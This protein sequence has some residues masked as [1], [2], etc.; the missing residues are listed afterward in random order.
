MVVAAGEVTPSKGLRESRSRFSSDVKNQ[1]WDRARLFP[2]REGRDP[3]RW[4]LDAA[5]N[6]VCRALRGC[7]GPLCMEFD[8]I[9]PKSR[10]GSGS[11]ENCQVLQSRLN[12]RKA[13]EFPPPE[14]KTLRVWS[15]EAGIRDFG[16]KELDIVELAIF[17]GTVQRPYVLFLNDGV[18]EFL[19]RGTRF[20]ESDLCYHRRESN[21]RGI[22][23]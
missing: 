1:C 14:R 20:S 11:V 15:E 6:P 9:H 21:L 16:G 2:N 19:P 23:T 22:V 12:R 3:T 13:D 8:H 10:G 18:M 4:R 17:G 5:G 7:V